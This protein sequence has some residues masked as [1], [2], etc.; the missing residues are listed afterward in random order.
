MKKQS[1]LRA[2][3]ES[4]PYTN[5]YF[6]WT[7]FFFEVDSSIAHPWQQ[8][9]RLIGV[10]L[11]LYVV[12]VVSTTSK[13]V[14]NFTRLIFGSFPHFLVVALMYIQRM[15]WGFVYSRFLKSSNSYFWIA[16]NSINF[17]LIGP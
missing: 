11:M 17:L 4:Y 16:I 2:L 10:P 13:E 14:K 15:K 3:P 1:H 9:V 6:I 7:S 12:L 5:A 8:L